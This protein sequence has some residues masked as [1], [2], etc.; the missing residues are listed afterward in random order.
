MSKLTDVKLQAW[1]RKRKPLSAKADGGGLYFRIHQSGKP[2]FYFRY[3]HAGKPRW[4]FLGNY[5]DTTLQAARKAATRARAGLD[6]GKDVAAERAKEK[7]E[8]RMV[9]T[10]AEL[11]KEWYEREVQPRVTAHHV[12]WR[13]LEKDVLK[14]IGAI[15]IKEVH[16][17]H[18][19][20]VLR[21]IADRDART[22]AND[23]LRYLRRM[24]A[25]GRRRHYLQTNPAEEFRIEDAG[26]KEEAR[27][28]ALS[29]AEL[30]K[31]LKAMR[32]T[33]NLERQN[34]LV[35]KL[36]LATCVRKGE[37]VRAL[38]SEF[39]LDAGIWHLPDERS[40][41]KKGLD[42]PLAAE[43][44]QW[45][46]EL[47]MFAGTSEYVLPIRRRRSGG[48]N[49]FDHM[50]PDTLNLALTR[51]KHGLEHFTVHDM[52]RTA[53]TQ[54]A[55]LGVAHEV[56]ERAL[57]HRMRGV[58]GTYNRHDYFEERRTALHQW[59]SILVSLEE[60]RDPRKVVPIREQA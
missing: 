57:N 42:I 41:N 46:R 51:V 3:R 14:H 7:A 47:K 12:V 1:V 19:D 49:R 58:A 48:R 15:P 31:L 36:L 54:L 25:F 43:V 53:R 27:G 5:P 26:G 50:S 10:V 23:A 56:A 9:T 22:V 18:V 38:W 8:A 60:G 32:E 44:V 24:F 35:F 52:R 20:K 39:D 40:K 45:L 30:S 55:A 21:A 33:P 29:L 11:A 2:Q 28:R 4:L 13:V 37:L 17:R 59:A 6:A 16:P 34:E